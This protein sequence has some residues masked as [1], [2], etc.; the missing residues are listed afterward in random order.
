MHGPFRSH[1]VHIRHVIIVKI[2]RWKH[3]LIVLDGFIVTGIVTVRDTGNVFVQNTNT[4][5]V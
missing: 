1:G 4:F 3:D 5:L 2:G